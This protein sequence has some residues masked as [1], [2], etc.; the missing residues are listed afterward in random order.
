LSLFSL[1][2]SAVLVAVLAVLTVIVLLIKPSTNDDKEHR[3][4]NKNK[5]CNVKQQQD[6]SWSA[7][8]W[9]Q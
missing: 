2:F 7:E 4:L 3:K 9:Q 6:A 5:H 8:G 1:L